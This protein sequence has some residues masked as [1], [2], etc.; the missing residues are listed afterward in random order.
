MES[1]NLGNDLV[2]ILVVNASPQY[3]PEII[4]PLV[5]EIKGQILI[6]NSKLN[7]EIIIHRLPVEVNGTLFFCK[8][9]PQLGL[10]VK[11]IPE[12]LVLNK[13]SYAKLCSGIPLLYNEFKLLNYLVICDNSNFPTYFRLLDS[14]LP[15]SNIKER[16]INWV[17]NG[18][19]RYKCLNEMIQYEIIQVKIVPEVLVHIHHPCNSQHCIDGLK[20]INEIMDKD[21]FQMF[22]IYSHLVEQNIYTGN[23]AGLPNF[24]AKFFPFLMGMSKENYKKLTEGK[25]VDNKEIEFFRAHLNNG[26]I[27]LER[28]IRFTIANIKYWLKINNEKLK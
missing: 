28:N 13:N 17:K 15:Y 8:E 7:I 14:V 19:D 26:E 11:N 9:M 6:F 21:E 24:R 1:N 10:L 2:C 16:I 12:L 23:I 4:D 5:K 3:T 25:Y 22:K 18:F 20:I 27:D